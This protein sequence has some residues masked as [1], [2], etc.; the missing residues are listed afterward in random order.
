MQ[1]GPE[2]SPFRSTDSGD[3]D[4]RVVPIRA[5][6]GAGGAVGNTTTVLLLGAGLLLARGGGRNAPGLA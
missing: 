1:V 3:G 6:T 5:D 4:C 2:R